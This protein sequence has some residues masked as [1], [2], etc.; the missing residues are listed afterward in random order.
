MWDAIALLQGAVV[1]LQP[2]GAAL[3]PA[4]GAARAAVQAGAAPLLQGAAD[5]WGFAAAALLPILGVRGAPPALCAGL[6]LA[7][8][9][10]QTASEPAASRLTPCP[11]LLRA[12]ALHALIV[13]PLAWLA[14]VSGQLRDASGAVLGWGAEV[15]RGI[16]AGA[17]V[18]GSTARAAGAVG[19]APGAL[20]SPG[21][22]LSVLGGDA[23]GAIRTSGVKV[24]RAS[25]SVAKVLLTVGDTAV[26]HRL[27]LSLRAQRAQRRAKAWL[28]ATA[29]VPV[30]AALGLLAWLLAALRLLALGVLEG[31]RQ[32][33]E[34]RPPPALASGQ[35]SEAGS[36]PEPAAPPPAPPPQQQAQEAEVQRRKED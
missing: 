1:V 22:W 8:L 11:P 5:L 30:H 20:G 33:E 25:Q 31:A 12:Q 24:A 27:T 3:G 28:R 32:K 15:G 21:T 10:T 23:L 4:F 2:L 6:F 35:P 13:G 19:G 29:A 36:D 14:A 17:A 26:R 7:L 34:A 16:A 18:V 9:A